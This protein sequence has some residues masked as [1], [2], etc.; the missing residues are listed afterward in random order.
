MQEN[1]EQCIK[2][3]YVRSRDVYLMSPSNNTPMA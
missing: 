2:K 1:E 3:N